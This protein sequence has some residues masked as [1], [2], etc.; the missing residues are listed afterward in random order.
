MY[1]SIKTHIRTQTALYLWRQADF[2]SAHSKWDL[3]ASVVSWNTTLSLRSRQ[4][5]VS[6][7]AIRPR[8]R[9]RFSTRSMA[10][11]GLGGTAGP[12]AASIHT[13]SPI[14]RAHA[15]TRPCPGSTASCNHRLK[16]RSPTI[17]PQLLHKTSGTTFGRRCLIDVSTTSRHCLTAKRHLVVRASWRSVF[18]HRAQYHLGEYRCRPTI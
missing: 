14:N 11:I 8:S 2:A 9:P 7:D 18:N 13:L 10:Q 12:R 6:R 17:G 5:P 3:P 1:R 15:A 4:P 16:H